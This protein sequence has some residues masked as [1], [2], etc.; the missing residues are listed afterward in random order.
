MMNWWG[1]LL[2]SCDC[3]L[4]PFFLYF[5]CFFLLL[6]QTI[7]RRQQAGTGRRGISGGRVG[8][9]VIWCRP[10]HR[11][12]PLVA[13]LHLYTLPILPSLTSSSNPWAHLLHCLSSCAKLSVRFTVRKHPQD[14]WVLPPK[15]GQHRPSVF[16]V[17]FNMALGQPCRPNTSSSLLLL[18][19]FVET[20]FGV[21]A[22]AEEPRPLVSLNIQTDQVYS[23][24]CLWL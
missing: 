17:S 13:S 11:K 7:W 18:A 16:R 9:H 19:I 21:V 23:E 4:M 3:N 24:W 6:S 2:Y 5:W 1:V 10:T 22:L 12:L 8:G 15:Q 14:L 20:I